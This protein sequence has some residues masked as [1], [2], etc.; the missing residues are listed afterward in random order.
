MCI[1]D[2]SHII[3]VLF[4]SNRSL[5]E[6]NANYQ[7]GLRSTKPRS[8]ICINHN[9]FINR[10]VI[11][12]ESFYREIAVGILHDRDENQMRKSSSTKH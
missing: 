4:E 2:R 8:L 5:F 10:H 11:S 12:D 7:R 1:G 3:S 9:F 6:E